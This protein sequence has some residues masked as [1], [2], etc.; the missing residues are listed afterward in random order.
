MTP[1]T[2][3][4]LGG[5]AGLGGAVPW[6]VGW[7]GGTHPSPLLTPCRSPQGDSPDPDCAG[8]PGLPGAPGIPGERGEQVGAPPVLLEAAGSPPPW[9]H[10]TAAVPPQGPPG[11]RGPPGPPGPIVSTRAGAEGGVLGCAST[12]SQLRGGLGAST[13]DPP[14]GP[15]GPGDGRR[16]RSVAAAPP[17]GWR[18]RRGRCRPGTEQGPRPDGGRGGP[19]AGC[20]AAPQGLSL[21]PRGGGGR[22]SRP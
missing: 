13:V 7:G 3:G 15:R 2:Q 22:V 4:L 8:D 1:G 9:C 16:M 6:V 12:A 21:G 14:G 11:L 20:S 19:P 5:L 18:W 10:L 17:W